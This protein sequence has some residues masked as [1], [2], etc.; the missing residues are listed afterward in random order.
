MAFQMPEQEV[1]AYLESIGLKQ[2]SYD[3]F[4]SDITDRVDS[5]F[6]NFLE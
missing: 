1:L 4:L 2:V 3:E 5:E 6:G